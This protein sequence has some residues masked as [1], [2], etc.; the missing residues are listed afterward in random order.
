MDMYFFFFIKLQGI[1]LDPSIYLMNDE[2]KSSTTNQGK[3]GEK[4][5]GKIKNGS[6]ADNHSTAAS[7]SQDNDNSGNQIARSDEVAS[8]VDMVS[9]ALENV[10]IS[11][12]GPE[13]QG[14]NCCFL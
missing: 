3:E 5:E 11:S 7:V 14:E 6:S 10:N 2:N 13:C 1:H 4:T 8:G 12:S 9:V